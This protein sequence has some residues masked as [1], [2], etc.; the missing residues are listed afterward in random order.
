[1]GGAQIGKSEGEKKLHRYCLK[2]ADDLGL[3]I[4]S[5]SWVVDLVTKE[6][7]LTVVAETGT[8]EV[9]YEPRDLD[10]YARGARVR[11]LNGKMRRS[12]QSITD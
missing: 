9:R 4:E 7:I 3:K 6:H 8:T 10:D 5:A 11:M 2:V 12:L 1:M